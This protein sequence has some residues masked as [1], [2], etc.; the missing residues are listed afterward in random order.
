MDI[1]VDDAFEYCT[2]DL[3][4]SS[5]TAFLSAGADCATLDES[6][7]APESYSTFYSAR[8]SWEVGAIAWYGE[9]RAPS[10]PVWKFAVP[11]AGDMAWD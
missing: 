9:F 2:T 7:I 3:A 8:L 1:S 4:F 11:H 10:T 5:M 6:G